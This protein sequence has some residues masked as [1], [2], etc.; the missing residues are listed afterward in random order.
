M[1]AVLVFVMLASASGCILSEQVGQGNEELVFH[2]DTELNRAMIF[3]RSV[4][5]GLIGVWL[6]AGSRRNA[7]PVLLGLATVA[8]ALG[9]MAMDYPK[10]KDYRVAV[11]VDGLHLTIPPEEEKYFPWASID[12]LYV[13]GMGPADGGGDS[14]GRLMQLPEWHTMEITAAGGKHRVDLKALSMEQRQ[15][16]WKA[17]ARYAGLVEIE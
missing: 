1:R 11:L 3:G 2:F 13:E 17:I 4:A 14:H 16:L 15:I 6:L 9:L 7:G 8:G 5:V 10:L 12:E